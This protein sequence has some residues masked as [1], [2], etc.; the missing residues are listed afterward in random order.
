M[1]TNFRTSSHTS[2]RRRTFGELLQGQKKAGQRLLPTKLPRGRAVRHMCNV[3]D[4]V[5]DGVLDTPPERTVTCD[6]GAFR[7]G[8]TCHPATGTL[9]TPA[10]EHPHGEVYEKTVTYVC[11]SGFSTAERRAPG[12]SVLAGRT[13]RRIPL[14]WCK[15]ISCGVAAWQHNHRSRFGQQHLHKRVQSEWCLCLPASR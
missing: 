7:T 1:P 10:A 11:Q 8:H 4:T 14:E 13:A 9:S 3:D 15:P 12:H 5:R 6:A 2:W